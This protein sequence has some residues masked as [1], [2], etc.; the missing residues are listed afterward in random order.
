MHEEDLEKDPKKINTNE[1]DVFLE[2]FYEEYLIEEVSK[3]KS[4]YSTIV[5][6][7]TN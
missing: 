2:I 5:N 7:D 1:K 3:I 6:E 4:Y